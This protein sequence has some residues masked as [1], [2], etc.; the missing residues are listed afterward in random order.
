M[1]KKKLEQRKILDLGCGDQ[2]LSRKHIFSNYDFNG[3]VIGLDLNKTEGADIICDLEK[4]KLPF[5]NDSFDIVF[6]SHCL[7]HIDNI[8]PLIYEIHR[9]LKKGGHFLVAVPHTSYID[10]MN[11]LTHK[12][13]F[14]Y[15]SFDFLIKEYHQQLRNKILFKMIKRKI[16]FSKIFKILGI[17]FLA[18]KFPILYSGFFT[19]IFQAREIYFEMEKK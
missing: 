1:F 18:N 16:V 14:G 5:E 7:E 2:K 10:S 19:G 9:V 15:N 12:R 3:K 6:T 8:I 17:E 11:D 13:L 4:G